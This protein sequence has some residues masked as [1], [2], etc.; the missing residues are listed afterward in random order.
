[1]GVLKTQL[2]Y[3][4]V[5]FVLLRQSFTVTTQAGLKRVTHPQ[6][7]ECW[8]YQDMPPHTAFGNLML[9]NC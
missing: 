1:M 7:P 9:L 6:L 4:F 8:N 2:L 3:F 5:C